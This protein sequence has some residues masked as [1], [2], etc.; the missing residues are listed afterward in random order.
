MKRTIVTLTTLF[1]GILLTT[2]VVF[3]DPKNCL[4]IYGGG[5]TCIQD[6]DFTIDKRVQNPGNQQFVDNLGVNDPTYA[7]GDTVTFA[8]T[9]KNV[10]KNAISNIKVTDT[11]PKFLDFV[12]GQGKFDQTKRTLTFS[13]AKLNKDESKT[14]IVKGKIVSGDK[15]PTGDGIG[16]IANLAQAQVGKKLSAD[17]AQFC[18]EKG[19]TGQTPAKPVPTQPTT[20]GGIPVMPTPKSQS[21]PATGPEAVSLLSLLP[22]GIAGFLLRKSRLAGGLRTKLYRG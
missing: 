10:S 20:K 4:P 8:L 18:I 9:V 2:G 6:K 11:Y 12:S 13:I 7:P 15:L 21:T 16:C 14:F 5:E 1:I 19:Q 3:A 22:T 17:N